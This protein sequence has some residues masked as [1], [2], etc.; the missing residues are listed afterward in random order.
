MTETFL[1]RTL[2]TLT[3]RVPEPWIPKLIG[4]RSYVKPHRRSIAVHG[5]SEPAIHGPDPQRLLRRDTIT[6]HTMI[7]AHTTSPI[8]LWPH[9]RKS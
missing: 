2:T 8:T 1:E 4:R 6:H 7:L 3:R 5:E 9:H